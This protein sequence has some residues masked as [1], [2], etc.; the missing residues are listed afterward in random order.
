MML[1]AA[2]TGSWAPSCRIKEENGVLS[3]CA[4]NLQSY[5]RVALRGSLLAG[6]FFAAASVFAHQASDSFLGLDAA[7]SRLRG[8]WVIALR[9]LDYAIQIDADHDGTI[10]L[11]E[12]RR[13]QGKIADYALSRLR[14]TVN[15]AACPTP[16]SERQVDPHANA[17]YAV[18]RFYAECPTPIDALDIDYRLFFDLDPQHH[19]LLRLSEGR[20]TQIAIFSPEHPSQHFDLGVRML[21]RQFL[22]FV[23]EGV[24]HIWIGFD[25]V[26]FLLALLLPA[27]LLFKSG[28]W[29]GVDRFSAGFWDVLKIVTAFTIAHSITL[30]L[31]AVQVI[32]LPSRWVEAAIAASVL[33][34]ALNNIFPVFR[35]RRWLVAFAF[36]LIHGFGFASV[37]LDLSLP[38]GSLLLA[39]VGF[40]LGVEAGQIVLVSAFLPAAFVL[41]NTWVYRRWVLIAGSALIALL[42]L[43]WLVE[44]AF[45]LKLINL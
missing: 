20:R 7:G 29:H 16:A 39:L 19:G 18:L 28:R 40:N 24:W 27:V 21:R 17:A 32:A 14:L 42:A 9:D 43:L 36:G 12:I 1:L 35:G 3:P 38:Q 4:V 5:G 25:H 23:R 10:T 34:A 2:V 44:R 37:L 13:T 26:L 41:R 31:A 22:A 6:L 33:L 8:E 15:G 45:N 11:D 30:S